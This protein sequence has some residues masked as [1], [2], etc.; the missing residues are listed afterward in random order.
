M[1]DEQRPTE[2]ADPDEGLAPEVPTTFAT[3]GLGWSGRESDDLDVRESGEQR[4][5]H[6]FRRSKGPAED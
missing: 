3:K 1:T 2:E 4:P 5:A 6:T